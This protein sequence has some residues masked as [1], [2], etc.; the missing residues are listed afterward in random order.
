MM[1]MIN[2]SW[3]FLRRSLG[4]AL[5]FVAWKRPGLAGETYQSVSRKQ[6]RA[7]AVI[8]TMALPSPVGAGNFEATS[9][10]CEKRVAA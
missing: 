4:I 3:A 6:R 7:S 10:S 1:I 9:P 8:R 5:E 2:F